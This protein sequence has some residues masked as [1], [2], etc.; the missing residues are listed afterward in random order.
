MQKL[1]SL[2]LWDMFKNKKELHLFLYS[3]FDLN[4]LF[5]NFHLLLDR[6]AANAEGRPHLR[7]S[8]LLQQFA[9]IFD[10]AMRLSSKLSLLQSQITDC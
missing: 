9:V 7:G 5:H 8:L 6:H 4:L 2:N 10:D 3:N 1:G